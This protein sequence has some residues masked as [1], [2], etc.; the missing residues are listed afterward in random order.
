M[1]SALPALPDDC[2]VTRLSEGSLITRVHH[3]DYPPVFF[4]PKPG[5]PP[6]NRF[7]APAGEF[8]TLYAA[9]SLT[10]GFVETILRRAARIVAQSFLDQRAW[11]VLRL[12]T[13]CD[14]ALLHGEGLVY[15]G[16]TNDICAGDDYKPSQMLAL[17]FF[18]K[19]PVRG[20]AYRARHNN[21]EICYAINER[22][23]AADL[24]LIETHRFADHPARVD[25]LLRLHGAA[26]DRGMPIP[27]AGALP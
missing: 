3:K 15:H 13:D 8:G 12:K 26:R 24:E 18:Q 23:S 4:G 25:A 9:H 1:T 11:S 2:L 21:D 5:E 6:K 20:I 7:D 27:P 14:L 17:A 16:V 10:G 22:Q 19:F